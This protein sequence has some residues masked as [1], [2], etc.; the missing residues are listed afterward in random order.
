MESSKA[1][2]HFT[3]TRKFKLNFIDNRF[4]IYRGKITNNTQHD[5]EWVKEYI[6]GDPFFGSGRPK[7][8]P[9]PHP[10]WLPQRPEDWK[11]AGNTPFDYDGSTFAIN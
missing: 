11:D 6:P 1:D 3:G 2:S 5:S 9:N 10:A 7:N 4:A 8:A